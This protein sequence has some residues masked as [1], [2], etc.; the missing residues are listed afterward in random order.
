MNILTDK[1]KI[2]LGTLNKEYKSYEK[3]LIALSGG[4][5]SCLAAFLGRKFLGKENSVAV[6]S[7]S[8][9]LKEKDFQIAVKFCKDHDISYEIVYTND[10]KL[11][12][13]FSKEINAGNVAINN[14]DA[15]VMNAP[16]GGWKDSGIG[17]EHG[18][19]GLYEYLQIKHVRVR[20]S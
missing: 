12:D 15:G 14:V 2:L 8:A 7:N 9:S 4:V 13:R 10:L 1:N 16:Y 3:V 19:E 18:P 20:Y 17:H 5:D 11:S 6:I